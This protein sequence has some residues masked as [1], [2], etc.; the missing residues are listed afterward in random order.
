MPARSPR[1]FSRMETGTT[2]QGADGTATVTFDAAFEKTPVIIVTEVDTTA[3]ANHKLYIT[4]ISKT[5]FTVAASNVEE[6]E[7]IHW[8]A[9]G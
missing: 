9:I 5:S 1:F 4:A 3:T 6:G 7:T 8:Q 2:T